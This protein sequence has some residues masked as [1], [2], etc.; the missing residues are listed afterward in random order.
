MR[1]LITTLTILLWLIIGCEGKDLLTPGQFTTEFAE[2]LRKAAP[3]FQVK[4]VQD[5]ELKI[6]KKGSDEHTTFLDNAYDSYKQEPR[7]KQDVLARYIASGIETYT[8]KTEIVD[9]RRIVPII[10]DKDW[11]EETNQAMLARGAKKPLEHVFDNYNGALVVVYAE[12]SPK[13][14]RYLTPSDV[15]QLKLSRERLHAMACENLK[16]ILPKIELHGNNGLYTVTAGG[17][18]EASL[19]LLDSIWN[20]ENLPVEGEIVVAIPTRD[21]L[22]VTGSYDKEGIS[23]LK[24]LAK[25]SY[26]EGSYRLTQQLFVRRG[27]K[28][29]S[30]IE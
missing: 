17:T 19:L 4:I 16:E 27:G 12:D 1:R 18:Y 7:E 14:I 25:K 21:L 30:F 13:N 26:D 24:A 6:T 8:A 2:A 22:L 3:G 15:S 11:L 23:K 28:F 29:M 9:K 5:L 20:K 10:K